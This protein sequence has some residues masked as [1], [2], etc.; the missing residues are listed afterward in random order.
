MKAH[1]GQIPW[2]CQEWLDIF[3]DVFWTGQRSMNVEKACVFILL[4]SLAGGREKRMWPFKSRRAMGRF[5]EGNFTK[6]ISEEGTVLDV[7][8]GIGG[9][10]YFTGV[11]WCIR[12][13]KMG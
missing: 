4:G 13:K 9:S 5:I 12:W 1:Y 3:T 2:R 6:S 8:S 7:R 10:R 11:R